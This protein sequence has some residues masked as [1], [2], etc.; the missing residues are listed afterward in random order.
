[1]HQL[2]VAKTKANTATFGNEPHEIITESAAADYLNADPQN[3]IVIY[4]IDGR[5]LQRPLFIIRGASEALDNF[6]YGEHPPEDPGDVDGGDLTA[7]DVLGEL[8]SFS[9]SAARH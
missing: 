5:D 6:Y 3:S 2:T 4:A 7:A 8:I 9:N 1:M